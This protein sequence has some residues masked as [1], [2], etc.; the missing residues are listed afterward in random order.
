MPTIILN[1]E[2]KT[3]IAQVKKIRETA[4]SPFLRKRQKKQ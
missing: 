1:K 2:K 4:K 3:E